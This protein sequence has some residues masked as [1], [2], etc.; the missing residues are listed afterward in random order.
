MAKRLHAI[1]AY[2]PRV[3]HGKHAKL[4]RLEEYVSRISMLR[5]GGLTYAMQVFTRA[6]LH[7]SRLGRPVQV[8]GLGTFLVSIRLDGTLNLGFRPDPD[9][10][11]ELNEGQFEGDI[12]GRKYIG[13]TSQELVDLWNQEH[14]DDPVE[15]A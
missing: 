15:E 6:L 10:R 4:P 13:K 12:R 3:V 1:N 2:R 11:S 5:H 9:L 8:K 14:P 7:Y